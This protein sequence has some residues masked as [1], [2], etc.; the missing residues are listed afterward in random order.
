[1]KFPF[2]VLIALVSLPL[3]APKCNQDKKVASQEEAVQEAKPLVAISFADKAADKME[4]HPDSLIIRYQRN[5]CFGTCPIDITEIYTSGL[6]VYTPR[7]NGL[8][9]QAS[10]SYLNEEQLTFLKAVIDENKFFELEDLYDANIPDLPGSRYFVKSAENKKE[11]VVKS[12]NPQ[13]LR[14]IAREIVNILKE[15][16]DWKAL[17]AE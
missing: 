8:V 17:P 12:G 5:A 9:E 13:E 6:V 4:N 14:P 7:L 1:M 3:L 16:E 2:A 11:I 15:I 10:M